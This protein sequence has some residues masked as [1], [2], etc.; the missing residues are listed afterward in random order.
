MK[1]G[2]TI[3]VCLIVIASCMVI[4]MI[5]MF[6]QQD[7]ANNLTS[8]KKGGTCEDSRYTD[9]ASCNYYGYRWIK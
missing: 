4:N 1:E 9:K 8:K 2:I 5:N 3:K 6:Y 7:K